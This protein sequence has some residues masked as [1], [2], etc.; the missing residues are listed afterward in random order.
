MAVA[1]GVAAAKKLFPVPAGP[2]A[3]TRSCLRIASMYAR[4]L[5]D[6]GEIRLPRVVVAT[7]SRI[8]DG[9]GTGASFASP[10]SRSRAGLRSD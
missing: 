8:S 10:M 4:W 5:S 7:T 1:M 3:N 9:A 6:C 2:T